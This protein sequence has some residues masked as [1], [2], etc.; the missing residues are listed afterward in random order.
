M[1]FNFYEE[2]FKSISNDNDECQENEKCCLITYEPLEDDYVTLECGHTFNYEPIY[3]EVFK[4]KYNKNKLEI[5]HICRNEIK[6]PYCRKI[7]QYLLPPNAKYTKFM[8]VNY[9]EKYC[10]K[11]NKCAYIFKSGKHKDKLCNKA[12]FKEYCNQHSKVVERNN[13]KN[14]FKN[15]NKKQNIILCSSLILSGE[16]KG[17][18][19]SCNGKF[20]VNNKYYC[21]RHKPK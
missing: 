1:D 20:I 4:Q 7:Q 5:Q 13:K 3:N 6:C 2:L 8:W 14:I 15:E 17:K 10:L 11:P 9:P 19:C 16:N 18:Q 12:C 21:G